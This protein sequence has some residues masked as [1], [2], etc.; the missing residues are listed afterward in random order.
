M[1]DWSEAEQH[2]ERAHD[3]YEAGRWDEAERELRRALSLNPFRPEWHFNLGLTLDAAGRL[4]DAAGALQAAHEL[5]PEDGPTLTLLAS[6]CLRRDD[7]EGAL[8][9]L[10]K[11]ESIEE[12]RA[13]ALLGKIEAFASLGRVE[14]AEL[15]FYELLQ[16][17][18]ESHHAP[19]YAAM[20]D[21][22][23]HHGRS[24]R[25]LYCLREAATRDP[26]LPRINARL[27]SAYAQTGRQERARQLFLRELR[28]MPGDLDTLLDLGAL[29]VDMN[30]FAEGA[31]KFRRVLEIEPDNADAHFAL[32]DIALR[33]QR[34]RDA[35]AAY[36][37]VERLDPSY[38]EV[39]RRLA[40]L[41][42]DR[43][44]LVAARRLL[45]L[46]AREM[47]EAPESFTPSDLE[48]LGQ[49]LLDARLHRDAADALARLVERTPESANAHHLLAVARFAL[50]DR[51]KAEDACRAALEIEPSLIP[52][53][54]NMALNAIHLRR[55]ARAAYFIDRISNA[56]PD[57]SALRRL[58]LL[59]RFGRLMDRLSNA[60]AKL[61]ARIGKRPQ[62]APR[63]AER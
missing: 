42:L 46:E 44:D 43:S 59:L 39:K 37:L 35:E 10:A 45:R 25:A 16:D 4:E 3:L 9:W 5:M 23:L 28:E 19:A 20:G 8:R 53:L 11:A 55:W 34:R 14:D 47:R 7:A 49:L 40:E 27:A 15:A 17:E 50:G 41:A 1:N 58:R 24:D 2:V 30:R 32:G 6:T 54:H 33:Q 38:P 60:L 56:D 61:R 51:E 18:E 52:A 31:E 57:D 12:V 29:L 21:A 22:L 36:R 13:D 63:S 26:D 48:D 62:G